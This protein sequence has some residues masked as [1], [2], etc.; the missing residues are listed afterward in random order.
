MKNF[1]NIS[2]RRRGNDSRERNFKRRDPEKR[3][4]G[5]R[6][7]ER[8]QMYEAICSDCGKKCEVPFKPTGDKPVYCSQCFT[9]HGGGQKSN[10]FERGDRERPRFEDRKMFDAI[11]DKCGKRFK[12][13]FKPTGGKPV[14][15]NECFDKGG[16][17]SSSDKVINQYKEQFDV[18]NVKLDKIIKILTPVISVKKEKKAVV[19]K[20]EK[21]KNFK[22]VLPK[23]SVDKKKVKK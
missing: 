5:N 3:Q 2:N 10:R 17:S 19:V 7:R 23:K 13:P 21:A 1:K 9:K 22:K 11:C 14:Y 16:D 8:P 6:D 12:L 20:K 4:F 15:C 18:L